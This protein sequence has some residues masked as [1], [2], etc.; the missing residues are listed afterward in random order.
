MTTIQLSEAV[1]DVLNTFPE[2]ER[3]KAVEAIESKDCWEQKPED[4]DEGTTILYLDDGYWK[5]YQAHPLFCV[6]DGV[7]ELGILQ[8]YPCGDRE[9]SDLEDDT[10]VV[11]DDYDKK[12][13]ALWQKLWNEADAAIEAYGKW[14]EDEGKDPLDRYWFHNC[15]GR[16]KP[17]WEDRFQV[18]LQAWY[19][20]QRICPDKMDEKELLSKVR[21]RF[22]EGFWSS[23][24]V[25][26]TVI[27]YPLK[28]CCDHPMAFEA[29]PPEEITL[30]D[31]SIYEPFAG[32]VCKKCGNQIQADNDQISWRET[33][34]D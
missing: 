3:E 33:G 25:G 16:E 30:C 4:F 6:T 5:T 23:L 26:R 17:D 32:W 2:E 24:R 1:L 15:N 22:P 7:L 31:D 21:E 14:V 20:N 13:D 18:S 29:D 11:D 12:A 28:Y 34:D 8:Y 27:E 9:W 19:I 10:V